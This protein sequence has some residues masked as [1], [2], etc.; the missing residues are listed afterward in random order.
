MGSFPQASL[1]S[2]DSGHGQEAAKN[3]PVCLARQRGRAGGTWERA[4]LP[5]LEG[6]EGPMLPVRVAA[7][8]GPPKTQSPPLGSFLVVW[9][10][11]EGFRS[12][13]CWD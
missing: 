10:R 8:S 5:G 6:T 12:R 1:A 2:S 11:R 7:N 13:L 9:V 4:H 3:L